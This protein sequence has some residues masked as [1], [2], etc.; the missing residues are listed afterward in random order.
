VTL[1]REARHSAMKLGNLAPRDAELRLRAARP[2]VGMMAA[3]DTRIETDED[4]RS[5]NSSGQCCRGCRLSSVYAHTLLQR[6]KILIASG[7]IRREQ[8]VRQLETGTASAPDADLARVHALDGKPLGVHAPQHLR[9]G[10][11]LHGGARPR[12]RP[13]PVRAGRGSGGDT[14]SRSYT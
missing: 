13:P 1:T 5:W 8:D 3:S 4:L 9:V 2:D 12:D 11:G 14:V 6:P 7:E 10:I